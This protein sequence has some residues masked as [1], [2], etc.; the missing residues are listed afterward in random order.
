MSTPKHRVVPYRYRPGTVALRE[1]RKFQNNTDH[2]LRK[3][4]FQ[5]LVHEIAAQYK[6]DLRFQT[7][8]ILALQEAAQAHL[9]GLFE[10][11]NL[12][13]IHGKRITITPKD[14]ELARRIRGDAVCYGTGK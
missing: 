13:A 3:F 6:D 9:V 1:I 14:I 8:A 4:L 5:R 7:S 11:T 12:A 10:E 2:I